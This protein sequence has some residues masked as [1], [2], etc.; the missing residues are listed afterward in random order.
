MED[1]YNKANGILQKAILA[2]SKGKGKGKS[3]TSNTDVKMIGINVE[4][5]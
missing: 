4:D 2:Q 3:S 1:L 5:Y